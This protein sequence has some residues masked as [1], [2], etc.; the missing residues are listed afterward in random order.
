ML[1]TTAKELKDAGF[2]NIQDVQHRQG[3]EFVTP[4]GRVSVYSLGQIAPTEDWF[5]P[6]LKELIEACE[7][8]NGC[9]HFILEHSQL[10]WFATIENSRKANLQRVLSADC[11]RGS[12]SPLVGIENAWRDRLSVDNL[13]QFFGPNLGKTSC[14]SLRKFIAALRESAADAVDGCFTRQ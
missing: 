2:P 13:P 4:N 10:G 11:R 5:I 8:K 6:T 14:R 9:D 7:K 12:S 1:L 3:R